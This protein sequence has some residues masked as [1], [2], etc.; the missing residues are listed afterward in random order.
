MHT[1]SKR[2]ICRGR[3]EKKG[4]LYSGQYTPKSVGQVTWQGRKGTQGNRDIARGHQ[5][6]ETQPRKYDPNRASSH[7]HKDE[8][9]GRDSA[10]DLP[11]PTGRPGTVRPVPRQRARPARRATVGPND[12]AAPRMARSRPD[13][14]AVCA[15]RRRK[16]DQRRHPQRPPPPA[17]ARA[18]APPRHW[19]AA[20]VLTATIS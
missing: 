7:G 13:C 15:T 16:S 5:S 17:P 9:G 14:A 18:L 8:E 4:Q 19:P 10:V 3:R 2:R 6:L 12:G 11:G 20:C 1:P